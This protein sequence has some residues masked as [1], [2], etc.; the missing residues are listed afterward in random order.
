[1]KTLP[2]ALLALGAALAIAPAASADTLT[3]TTTGTL[4]DGVSSL[5]LVNVVTNGSNVVTSVG[6]G[7]YI[8]LSGVKYSV[9]GLLTGS[10]YDQL[11]NGGTSGAGTG[12]P[13]GYD[14]V[15][16]PTTPYL[17]DLG[18]A[19]SI[20]GGPSGDSQNDEIQIWISSGLVH[21]S[22]ESYDPTDLFNISTFSKPESILNVTPTST[23]EPDTLLLF[24]TGLLGLAGLLRSKFLLSR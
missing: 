21:I 4:G 17:D 19:F 7:S 23:P 8:E 18:L 15:L 14:Q 16:S 6:A 22:D 1:M 24:G 11:Y 13:G 3:V 12:T 9:V 5:D 10:T 2:L 20:N